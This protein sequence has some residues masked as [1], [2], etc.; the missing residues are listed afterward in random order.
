M[1][2]KAVAHVVAISPYDEENCYVEVR[3]VA[4][5]DGNSM[6]STNQL[7]VVPISSNANADIRNKVKEWTENEW[8]V[9]WGLLDTV[10]LFGGASIL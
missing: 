3:I 7:F 6:E 8:A 4:K 1:A 5:Q 2:I 10:S 9:S